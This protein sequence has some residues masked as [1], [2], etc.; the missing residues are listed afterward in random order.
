MSTSKAPPHRRSA[1]RRIAKANI[2]LYFLFVLFWTRS[3]S[4]YHHTQDPNRVALLT[5]RTTMSPQAE[6]LEERAFSSEEEG[7]LFD[8]INNLN[9]RGNLEPLKGVE[10]KETTSNA[11][12]NSESE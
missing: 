4:P 8:N 5:L 9:E 10:L 2:S 7:N 3:P 6:K 1:R 12:A 11:N